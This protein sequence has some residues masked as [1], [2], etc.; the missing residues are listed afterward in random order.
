MSAIPAVWPRKL[1]RTEAQ[2]GDLA[3]Q[4]DNVANRQAASYRDDRAGNLGTDA[5]Q[6]RRFHLRGGVGGTLAGVAMALQPKGVKIGLADPKGRRCMPFY[7]GACWKARARRS[8][9]GSGR[10]GSPRTLKGSNPTSAGASRKPRRCRSCLTGLRT[11][12][13]HGGSTGINIAGP[14]EWPR[15]WARA[16]HRHHPVRLWQPLPVQALQPGLPEEKGLPVPDWLDRAPRAIPSVF[17][18]T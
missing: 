12:A 11:R 4:F 3:N 9:K 8:P 16:H 17:A 15:R 18:D 2:R 10:G 5:G 14:S 1:A 13:V 6:G 7:T